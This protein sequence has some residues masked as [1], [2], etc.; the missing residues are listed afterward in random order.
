MLSQANNHSYYRIQAR[1]QKQVIPYI[2]QFNHYSQARV[3]VESIPSPAAARQGVE[4][5]RNMEQTAS[6]LWDNAGR[7]SAINMSLLL[8]PPGPSDSCHQPV[9]VGKLRCSF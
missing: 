6:G 9:T 5:H 4:L 1:R 7:M 3:Y 2:G 8:S